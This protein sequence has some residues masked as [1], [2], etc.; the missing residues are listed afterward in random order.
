MHENAC[1]DSGGNPYSDTREHGMLYSGNVERF[2]E[3]FPSIHAAYR[4]R[5]HRYLARLVGQGEAE[6]LTQE[7]FLSVSRGLPDLKGGA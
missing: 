4:P 2:T 5:I 6:D 3:D 7:V 1:P